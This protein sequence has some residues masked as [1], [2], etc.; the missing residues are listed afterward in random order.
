MTANEEIIHKFYSAFHVKD[1]TKMIELYDD[2]IVFEDPAFG[3]LNGKRAKSMWI[4]LCST[5][6]DLEISFKILS[7]TENEVKAYWE[8][9]YTF[10][11]T[12][13][14]IHNKI[15]ASFV[16]KDGLIIKH[17]DSFDLHSWA[18][19]GLGIQGKLLGWTGFF[20]K[21]LNQQTE[22]LLIRF[23]NENK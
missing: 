22:G 1:G 5:A 10:S 9:K 11:R 8:A 16:I 4:M 18:S 21:K 17:T 12:G 23:M 3:V 6:K 19:Q 14:K 20:K 13:R 7:S 15:N 2:K